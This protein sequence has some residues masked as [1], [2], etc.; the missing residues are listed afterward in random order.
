MKYDYEQANYIGNK[1]DIVGNKENAV[2]SM[3]TTTSQQLPTN[4]Q[5]NRF[6]LIIRQDVRAIITSIISFVSTNKDLSS[7]N[8]HNASISLQYEKFEENFVYYLHVLPYIF[9]NNNT[10]EKWLSLLQLRIFISNTKLSELLKDNKYYTEMKNS[11]KSVWSVSLVGYDI[12]SSSVRSVLT[13]STPSSQ[14]NYTGDSNNSDNEIAKKY[15]DKEDVSR[16]YKILLQIRKGLSNN[17]NHSQQPS[18]STG[19]SHL[20]LFLD[21]LEQTS[22]WEEAYNN[23][24]HIIDIDT[25]CANN[26]VV[27]EIL[28]AEYFQWKD[29]YDKVF[30]LKAKIQ[31]ILTKNH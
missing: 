20:K 12:T 13:G 6:C 25:K 22:L 30:F 1:Q 21:Y 18:L 16:C 26:A 9:K 7:H 2:S 23:L 4:N 31:S 29:P 11:I 14:L 5:I 27:K 17:N 19:A 24:H 15:F 8:V 10:R 28:K 3:M